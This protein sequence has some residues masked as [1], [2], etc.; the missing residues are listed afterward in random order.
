MIVGDLDVVR[1]A[2][3]PSKADPPLVVD[4]NAVLA[5]AIPL[6]CHQ[7]ISGWCHQVLQRS[8]PMEIEQFASSLPFDAAEPGNRHVVE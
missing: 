5:P 4:P 7:A 2:V 8:C 6:E 3:F 1:V